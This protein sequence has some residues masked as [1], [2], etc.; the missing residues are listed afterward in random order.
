[1]RA[2]LVHDLELG[3][4]LGVVEVLGLGLAGLVEEEDV[5]CA[6]RAVLDRV[7]HRLEVLVYDQLR[8]ERGRR[9]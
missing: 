8:R 5:L 6:G 9:R 3:T 4:G 2:C 7:A 1:L